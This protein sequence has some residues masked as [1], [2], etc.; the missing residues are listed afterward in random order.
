MTKRFVAA[1]LC[2]VAIAVVQSGARS[3]DVTQSFT[4]DA[5]KEVA[6][7]QYAY[8]KAPDCVDNGAGVTITVTTAPAHGKFSTRSGDFTY[9]EGISTRC[10][11]KTV[12]GTIAYYTPEAGFHGEDRFEIKIAWPNRSW[13][14][15]VTVTVS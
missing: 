13:T 8:P 4:T 5:G 15:A 7:G 12:T 2:A 3:A 6:V 10:L 1:A 14:K 9:T 11:G